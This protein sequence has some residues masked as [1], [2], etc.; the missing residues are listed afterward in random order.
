[1]LLLLL[2]LELLFLSHLD[3]NVYVL[4]QNLQTFSPLLPKAAVPF[5]IFFYSLRRDLLL[6]HPDASTHLEVNPGGC[7][8][9]EIGTKGSVAVPLNTNDNFFFFGTRCHTF[10][11]V[12]SRSTET[13][14]S[15]L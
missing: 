12:V 13:L 4:A 7:R 10:D 6:N 5:F 8:G 15:R 9:K 14:M 3:E 1:M 11:S 2:I